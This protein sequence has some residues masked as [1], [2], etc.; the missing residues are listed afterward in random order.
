MHCYAK[1]VYGHECS[2]HEISTL[3][4]RVVSCAEPYLHWWIEREDAGVAYVHVSLQSNAP[5]ARLTKPSTPTARLQRTNRLA[6]KTP[7]GQL[8]PSQCTTLNTI[9][10][11]RVPEIYVKQPLFSHLASKSLSEVSSPMRRKDP[12]K[13]DSVTITA[14]I[15][16]VS[17]SFAAP[18]LLSRSLSLSRSPLFFSDCSHSRTTDP[19]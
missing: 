6:H 3:E 10:G 7:Q 13:S 8:R 15:P 5:E 11:P 18:F 9:A 1:I 16:S 12:A 19:I 14:A 2:T 4:N 17:R